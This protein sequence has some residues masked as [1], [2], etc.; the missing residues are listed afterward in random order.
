LKESVILPADIM[1]EV[2]N[3]TG[4]NRQLGYTS[5]EEFVRDAIRRRLDVL[6]ENTS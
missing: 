2:E 3:S 1:A 6:N 5:K 4:E